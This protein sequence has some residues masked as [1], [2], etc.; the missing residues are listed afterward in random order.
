MN[1]ERKI[2][3]FDT[4]PEGFEETAA[5]AAAHVVSDGKLLLLEGAEGKGKA[6][7]FAPPAGKM[8]VGETPLETLERELF[9]E[10]GIRLV[11][12]VCPRLL[13]TLYIS[14]RDIDY[15]YHCFEVPFLKPP[16]ITLSPEHRSYRW[17]TPEASA[18]LPLIEG[19]K[20]ILERYLRCSPAFSP[21]EI[22]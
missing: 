16:S 2:R 21:R 3:I 4:R 5:V 22:G 18:H 11:N 19:G 12:G 20:V 6:G 7:F 8:E 15:L 1:P 9:E 14:K 13:F 10:T 17:E